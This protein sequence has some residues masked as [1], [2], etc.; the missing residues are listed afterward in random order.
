MTEENDYHM[1]INPGQLPAGEVARRFPIASQKT[2]D[3]WN[4]PASNQ[5]TMNWIRSM[6]GIVSLHQAPE[7]L[8]YLLTG[9]QCERWKLI[10]GLVYITFITLL[11][12]HSWR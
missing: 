11:I 8:L 6:Y 5:R 7:D 9:L 3:G 10:G 12:V 1:Q 4:P 2:V